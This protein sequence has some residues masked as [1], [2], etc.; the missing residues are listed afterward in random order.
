MKSVTTKEAGIGGIFG[1]A[2]FLVA[3]YVILKTRNIG[4][5]PATKSRAD[6]DAIWQIKGVSKKGMT[7]LFSFP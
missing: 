6:F 7:S 2:R 4:T 1:N 3:E 5:K